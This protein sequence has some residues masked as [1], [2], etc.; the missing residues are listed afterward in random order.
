[1]AFSELSVQSGD[2]IDGVGTLESLGID[3]LAGFV[4]Q[5]IARPG[6]ADDSSDF[7]DTTHHINV[8]VRRH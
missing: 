3:Q 7:I 1:V 4:R 5:V 2:A 8:I 6:W